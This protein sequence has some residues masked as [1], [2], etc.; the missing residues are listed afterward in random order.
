MEG[1]EGAG[2]LVY[3]KPMSRETEPISILFENCLVRN[4]NNQGIVVGAVKD[5]GPSG[6]I[7]FRNC[8]VEHSE[9]QELHIYDKSADAA[10][11][12]FENCKWN[13]AVPESARLGEGEFP[14]PLL[15]AVRRAEL[16]SVQGGV[17]FGVCHL[18]DNVDRAALLVKGAEGGAGPRDISGDIVV[19]NPHGAR[20]ELDPGAGDVNVQL[21]NVAK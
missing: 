16:V 6:R 2:I 8:T 18:Y 19:H 7:E 11:I 14:V 10:R 9:R 1:N 12:R 13:A 21:T 4:G 17:E 20:M 5:D 3:L 15:I